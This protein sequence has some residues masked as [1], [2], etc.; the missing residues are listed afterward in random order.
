MFQA[1]KPSGES[2]VEKQADP[3]PKLE[4]SN[5]AQMK[6]DAAAAALDVDTSGVADR[7]AELAMRV[8][9]RNNT[10]PVTDLPEKKPG[11]LKRF[12]GIFK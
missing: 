11:L 2:R 10:A 9:N 4:R 6:A 5:D 12:I 1:P 8:P 3:K 7:M